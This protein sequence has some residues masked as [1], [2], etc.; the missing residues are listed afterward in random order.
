MTVKQTTNPGGRSFERE[1]DESLRIA[2]AI[3]LG[4]IFS[5]VFWIVV[6]IGSRQ[7]GALLDLQ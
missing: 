3:I 5:P 7:V 4:L 2:R 1:R 6:V